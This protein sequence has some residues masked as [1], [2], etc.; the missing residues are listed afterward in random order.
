MGIIRSV[1][2]YTVLEH[3]HMGTPFRNPLITGLR[4]L[5]R[6][7]AGWGGTEGPLKEWG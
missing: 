1:Y 4:A 6:M 3:I 5:I 2:G 7:A